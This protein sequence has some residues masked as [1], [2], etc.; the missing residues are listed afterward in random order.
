MFPKKCDYEKSAY[1]EMAERLIL[2]SFLQSVATI[3]NSI[4]ILVVILKLKG[5]L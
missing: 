2:L 5:L 1:E 3:G 4:A